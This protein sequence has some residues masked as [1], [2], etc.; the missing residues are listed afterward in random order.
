LISRRFQE[1]DPPICA[2]FDFATLAILVTSLSCIAY[3]RSLGFNVANVVGLIW[4][5]AASRV[6]SVP[7]IPDIVSL[8]FG[9][10]LRR[11]EAR[12]P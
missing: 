3:R 8:A 4:Q 2:K 6:K 5:L 9:G 7:H 11:Q 10:R 12:L 1:D